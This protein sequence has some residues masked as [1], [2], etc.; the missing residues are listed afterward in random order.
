MGFKHV[1]KVTMATASDDPY[2]SRCL[3]RFQMRLGLLDPKS[4]TGRA[5]SMVQ[6]LR[7]DGLGSMT[8]LALHSQKREDQTIV[9]R[10]VD[11][12]FNGMVWCFVI[13]RKQGWAV[14]ISTG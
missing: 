14:P 12:L 13:S 2:T 8:Q 10:Q 7:G 9:H 4:S 5:E 11:E 6:G 3:A 1:C